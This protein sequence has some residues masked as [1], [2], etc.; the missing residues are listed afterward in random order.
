MCGSPKREKRP[1]Y[2]QD[3]GNSHSA[4]STRREAVP[5]SIPDG[6]HLTPAGHAWAAEKLYEALKT[7]TADTL[8]QATKRPM[9][10]TK[11]GREQRHQ[12]DLSLAFL[13]PSHWIEILFPSGKQWMESVMTQNP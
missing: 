3:T 2:P 6:I 10:Q 7:F 11:F 1:T 13:G 5:L 4:L 8:D 12:N 9:A